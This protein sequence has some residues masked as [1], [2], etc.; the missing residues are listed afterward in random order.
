MVL[1]MCSM[2]ESI[3]MLRARRRAGLRM[4][5]R[6]LGSLLVGAILSS[7]SLKLVVV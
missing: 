2:M 4:S 5:L 1:R 7:R 3:R 6:S